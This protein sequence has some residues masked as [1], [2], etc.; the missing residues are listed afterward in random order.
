MYNLQL[1]FAFAK[2]GGVEGLG[3][4]PTSCTFR[5]YLSISNIGAKACKILHGK[6]Q[7]VQCLQPKT[8]MS[9]YSTIKTSLDS[10]YWWHHRTVFCEM[11]CGCGRSRLF[12]QA[13]VAQVLLSCK[14]SSA[15]MCPVLVRPFIMKQSNEHQRSHL[16]EHGIFKLFI[17][18]VMAS[19]KNGPWCSP[20]RIQRAPGSKPGFRVSAYHLETKLG[21]LPL[22]LG[23]NGKEA[24]ILTPTCQLVNTPGLRAH[25]C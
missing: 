22:V 19:F 6:H 14:S 16:M 15:K 24:S 21:Q 4:G 10:R 20:R 12:W 9:G 8:T 25:I 11:C 23:H 2:I 13:R 18:F 3:H 17:C 5:W 7:H 1:I